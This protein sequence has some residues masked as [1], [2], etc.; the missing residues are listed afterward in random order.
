MK[1]LFEKVNDYDYN[2][3]GQFKRYFKLSSPNRDKFWNGIFTFNI[4]TIVCL[5]IGLYRRKGVIT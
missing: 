4:G 1:L 5:G 3:T 2:N